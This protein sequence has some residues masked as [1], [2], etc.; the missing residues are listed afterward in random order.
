MLQNGSTNTIG[1]VSTTPASVLPHGTI[2]ACFTGS[3]AAEMLDRDGGGVPVRWT[4]VAPSHSHV[5]ES[6]TLPAPLPPNSTV[7]PSTRSVAKPASMRPGGR[8]AG[9]M[10][11]QVAPFQR[12]MSSSAPEPPNSTT[13]PC[14]S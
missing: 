2:T 6:P 9:V 11:L 3:Y 4:H 1:V 8:V 7:L 10:L 14:G 5:S 12:H 13:W